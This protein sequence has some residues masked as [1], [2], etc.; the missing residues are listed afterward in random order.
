[1]MYNK[2]PS[3]MSRF[4][5]VDWDSGKR[6]LSNSRRRVAVEDLLN[7]RS[8]SYFHCHSQPRQKAAVFGCRTLR[9]TI[10]IP[11]PLPPS[12]ICFSSFFQCL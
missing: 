8:L 3:L 9:S 2:S 10:K 7:P 4:T 6:S 1:L 5:D 11:F 12:P